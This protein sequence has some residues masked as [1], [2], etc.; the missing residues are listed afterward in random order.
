MPADYAA[1]VKTMSNSIIQEAVAQAIDTVTRVPGPTAAPGKQAGKPPAAAAPPRAGV[2]TGKPAQA[3]STAARGKTGAVRVPFRGKKFP[4]SEEEAEAAPPSA[5]AVKAAKMPSPKASPILQR[6]RR[7]SVQ[8]C[9]D[10]DQVGEAVVQASL[11]AGDAPVKAR[12]MSFNVEAASAPPVD[13][14]AIK[15]SPLP[16]VTEDDEVRPTSVSLHASTHTAKPSPLRRATITAFDTTK[17]QGFMSSVQQ[18][19]PTSPP[20]LPLSPPTPAAPVAP[21][22][23]AGPNTGIPRP[24]VGMRT[25]APEDSNPSAKGPF[26]RFGGRPEPTGDKAVARRTSAPLVTA[27]AA[28]AAVATPEASSVPTVVTKIPAPAESAPAA[29]KGGKGKSAPVT[30]PTAAKKAALTAAATAAAATAADN[31]TAA[32]NAA[33]TATAVA[34]AVAKASSSRLLALEVVV[35]TAP[36]TVIPAEVKTAVAPTA[37]EATK[38]PSPKRGGSSPGSKAGKTTA[39][40]PTAPAAAAVGGQGKRPTPTLRGGA[41]KPASPGVPPEAQTPPV[42]DAAKATP[43]ASITP[44]TTPVQKAAPF[45]TPAAHA[46][47]PTTTT[48]QKAIPTPSPATVAPSTT[49]APKAIPATTPA[50]VTPTPKPAAG[51]TATPPPS[52][53]SLG[54]E[55]P[56]ARKL[57][58]APTSAS[59]IGDEEALAFAS[60]VQQEMGE[61]KKDGEDEKSAAARELVHRLRKCVSYI[62]CCACA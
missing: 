62:R 5:P 9:Q 45:T 51:L 47:A 16:A 7:Q 58:A 25:A 41:P 53:P 22:V 55:A 26:S 36:V 28:A 27:A 52:R 37:P 21:V 1:A 20:P 44:T 29:P 39:A 61:E 8:N 54:K 56:R 3:V 12:R 34:A 11:V 40:K 10:P 33:A 43:A 59:P 46:A 19:G 35:A 13:I 50:A 23:P 48:V 4:A 49:P 31:A 30:S 57:V 15:R 32:A 60:Q 38:Q 2:P 18:D 6:V 17:I 14:I 42:E 24:K